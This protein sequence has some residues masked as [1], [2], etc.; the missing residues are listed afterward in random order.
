MELYKVNVNKL[1][2]RSGPVQSFANKENVVAVLPKDAIFRSVSMFTNELSDWLGNRE[3]QVISKNFATPLDPLPEELEKYHALLPKTFLDFKL[4]TFWKWS[5]PP[6]LKLGII[7]TGHIDTGVIQKKAL[8]QIVVP[9][10]NRE[11]EK[12]TPDLGPPNHATTMACIIC[13][14]APEEGIVGAA[15]QIK[16]IYNYIMPQE[17]PTPEMFIKALTKMEENDVR[18]INISYCWSGFQLATSKALIDKAKS[19][20]ER[21]FVI[22]CATGNQFNRNSPYFPAGYKDVISVAGCSDVNAQYKPSSFWDSVNVCMRAEY[23]FNRKKFPYSNGTSAAAAAVTGSIA[24]LYGQINNSNKIIEL[25]NAFSKCDTVT[26][27]DKSRK[28]C[29][30]P[31]FNIDIFIHQIIPQI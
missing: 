13:G 3:G 23:Y 12:P 29:K 10:N 9:L 11:E 26:F 31:L 25:Q 24:H 28:I 16:K 5:V 6:D 14:Y 27:T 15:P 22:V 21:G 18:L 17:K 4:G 8:S 20:S 19:M 1:N 7:D 30:I 2:L